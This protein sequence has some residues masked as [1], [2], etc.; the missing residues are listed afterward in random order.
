MTVRTFDRW[1]DRACHLLG[2]LLFLMICGA[3]S[4]AA[5][6]LALP[7]E[8][9]YDVIK[10]EIVHGVIEPGGEIGMR[11]LID[12]HQ[13]DCWRQYERRAVSRVQSGDKPG[14][15]YKFSSDPEQKLPV[16]L[17]GEWQTWTDKLPEDF[18]CGPAYLAETVTA[19]C[20][21]WQ[22]HIRL[23]RKPDIITPFTVSCPQ[24]G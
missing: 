1:L 18:T 4:Y 22:R 13:E 6:S 24:G 3:V 14:M 19:A 12:Y 15:V 11:R 10:R 7:T 17:S 21:F 23:L 16:Y 5:G 20:T 9:P 2:G 8:W